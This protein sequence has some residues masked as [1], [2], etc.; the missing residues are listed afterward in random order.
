MFALVKFLSYLSCLLFFGRADELSEELGALVAID[1]SEVNNSILF[2]FT[3]ARNYLSII[4]SIFMNLSEIIGQLKRI[5]QDLSID[6]YMQ[7][8][9]ISLQQLNFLL[10][11]TGML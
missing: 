9:I 2:N 11:S 7:P 1:E 5:E 10:E 4:N 8:H 3:K 6:S